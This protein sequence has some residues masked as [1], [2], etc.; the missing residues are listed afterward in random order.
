VKYRLHTDSQPFYTW[1][2]YLERE[3]K[4]RYGPRGIKALELA[5]GDGSLTLGV[6]TFD[7]A[8]EIMKHGWPEGIAEARRF[9]NMAVDK[10]VP[11]MV[12]GMQIV[13]DVTGAAYDVG[14]LVS[15]VPEAWYA[16]MELEKSKPCVSIM[17]DAFISYG[18][19]QDALIKRG[20]AT[21]AL[22]M[23][24]QRAGYAVEVFIV[25]GSDSTATWHDTMWG[26]VTL[27]DHNGGPLDIDR[28]AGVIAHPAT[29]RF[30]LFQYNSLIA[31][32]TPEDANL[33][34]YSSRVSHECPW[35]ADVFVPRIVLNGVDWKDEKS[36]MSWVEARFS[37][38]TSAKGG[39]TYA[40]E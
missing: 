11:H 38:I 5:F 20:A 18:V 36:I 31:N 29:V 6:K 23:A 1:L 7:Q 37:E 27:E 3:A 22:V 2:P 8:L 35:K 17:V 33:E 19:T 32:Q 16:P 26:R 25:A 24:L 4:A 9:A 10:L 15:G 14:A 12:Q 30:L 39:K 40:Q 13:Q 21:I 34:S 28:L